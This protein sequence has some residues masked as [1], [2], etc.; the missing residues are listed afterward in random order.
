MR[1]ALTVITCMKSVSRG[2]LL[3]SLGSFIEIE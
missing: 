3:C 1:V 2:V